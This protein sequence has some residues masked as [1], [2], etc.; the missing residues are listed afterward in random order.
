[1]NQST[2][3]ERAKDLGITC[4]KIIFGAVFYYCLFFAS[5]S[6][7]QQTKTVLVTEAYTASIPSATMDKLG[8]MKTLI[9]NPDAVVYKCQLLELTD[10]ATLKKRKAQ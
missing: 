6:E 3:P 2:F 7:A 9:K 8:A 5:S 4:L 10:K 1:M